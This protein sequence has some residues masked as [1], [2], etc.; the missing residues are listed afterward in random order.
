MI[1][2]ATSSDNSGWFNYI[3]ILVSLIVVGIIVIFLARFQRGIIGVVLSIVSAVLLIYWVRELK[4]NVTTTFGQQ[5][6]SAPKDPLVDI[7]K[8]ADGL[9]IVL[10]VPGPEDKVKTRLKND[11]LEITGGQNFK[12]TIDLDLQASIESTTYVNGILTV[13]LSKLS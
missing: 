1:Q 11:V 6:S 2:K 10:E 4:K 9:T 7:I 5:V 8:R 13:K 3:V 12:K